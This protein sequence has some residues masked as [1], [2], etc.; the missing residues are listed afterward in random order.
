M[1]IG[2][3][4]NAKGI[5]ESFLL[6]HKKTWET[7]EEDYLVQGTRRRQWEKK[8]TKKRETEIISSQSMADW[9]YQS[10]SEELFTITQEYRDRNHI[11]TSSLLNQGS[12]KWSVLGL[13]ICIF[14]LFHCCNEAAPVL[15]SRDIVIAQFK[16]FFTF[17]HGVPLYHLI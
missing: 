1:I 2:Q 6:T 9:V 8:M 17:S 13:I 3:Q 16:R 15:V 4:E 7:Q 12:G 5:W 11:P 10:L 14:S